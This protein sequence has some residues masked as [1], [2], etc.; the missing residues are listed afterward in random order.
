MLMRRFIPLL[1][2]LLLAGC[3]SYTP[4]F[5]PESVITKV[6]AH[7]VSIATYYI[8]DDDQYNRFMSSKYPRVK[9]P[10]KIDE[11]KRAAAI[12]GSGTI[13]KDNY[14]ITVRHMFDTHQ[15]VEH[16]QI[17]VFIPGWDHAVEA[18]LVCK[19]EDGTFWDDYAVIK[20]REDSGLPGLRI[21]DTQPL[22][23][24][25][26]INTGS[27]GGFAFFTRY[28]R[29][30]ELQWHFRRGYDDILHLTPF[31]DFPYMCVFPGGPGDSGG[32]ICNTRG[33]L[34]GIMYCGLTNY[35]EEYV[36]ANPLAFLH[37]FLEKNELSHLK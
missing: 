16:S 37:E 11:P 12:I 7:T 24:E 1:A 3:V 10:V 5:A 34:V 36:F 23:G 28:S 15:G 30:A 29:I 20:L 33:E 22:P 17:Y 14:V 32:S 35:S 2:I 25:K 6:R 9:Y 4:Q 26:I 27:T 8:M 31:E 19:S 21:G 13:L 18:D